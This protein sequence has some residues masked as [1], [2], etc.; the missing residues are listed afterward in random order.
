MERPNILRAS[1]LEILNVNIE[2]V[3][4]YKSEDGRTGW[5]KH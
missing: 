1:S 5:E 4:R 3:N 2:N